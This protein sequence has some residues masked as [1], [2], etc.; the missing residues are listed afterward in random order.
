M[1]TKMTAGLAIVVTVIV[2]AVLVLRSSPL[3]PAATLKFIG[4]S[5]DGSYARFSLTNHTRHSLDHSHAW[6]QFP[7]T[8]GWTDYYDSEEAMMCRLIGPLF[9]RQTT[10]LSAA[11]PR[12]QD[13]WRA[14]VQF[15]VMPDCESPWRMRFQP[16]LAFLHLDAR[17][18]EVTL[19][20]EEFVR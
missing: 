18:N 14:S 8:T 6:I 19:T 4:Y 20:T 5:A 13:R 9:S 1:R 7:A 10:T 17:T 15:T 16:L 11:L 12:G 3:P 2:S